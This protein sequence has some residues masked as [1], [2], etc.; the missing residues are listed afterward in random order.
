MGD[1]L[2][3][4]TWLLAA[5]VLV[6]GLLTIRWFV[7]PADDEPAGADA[8]LVFAGG[9]GERLDEGLAL[10]EQD[11]ANVLVVN[12][13]IKHWHPTAAD[14][15]WDLCDTTPSDYTLICIVALPDNTR[16]EAENFADI[17]HEQGWNSVV[18]VTTDF[19]SRRAALWMGRCFDGQV[20]RSPADAGLHVW[21]IARE[22][23]AVG[24]TTFLERSC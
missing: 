6:W 11:V 15:T 20:L 10:I 13:A 7:L 2:R 5:A 21:S 4:A 17:A 16:G 14:E 9:A 18:V 19:H 3:R 23:L 22:W 24:Q 12:E 1:F 8:V